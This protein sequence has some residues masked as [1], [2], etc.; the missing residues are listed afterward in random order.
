MASS[1]QKIEG[2]ESVL[3]RVTHSNLKSFNPDIR[4]SLQLT[5]EAVKDKLW[6]KCG[7]SVNSMHLELYDELR[8]KIADL[9]DHSKL[10][11]FY[12]PFDGLV[13]FS[14]SFSFYFLFYSSSIVLFS[15][16]TFYS[17]WTLA[18]FVCT[19]LILIQPLLRRVDG[20]KIL[21]WWRN[22]KFL[23]KPIIS[24]E[25]CPS[26]TPSNITFFICEN[27]FL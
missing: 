7:T 13:T 23:K 26:I 2:D 10:L 16:F 25:A 15:V 6:K 8:N 14:F 21:L 18:G 20:W 12:S 27:W 24:E 19:S 3:L 11:G 17:M 4:F 5:V 1:L 22:M 9:S